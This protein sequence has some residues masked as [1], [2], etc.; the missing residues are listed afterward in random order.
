MAAS[1]GPRSVERALDLLDAVAEG[2]GPVSAKAL[3]RRVGC[4]LS[5]VYHLLGTLTERGHVVRTAR[6]YALGHRVPHLHRAYGRQVRT[7]AAMREVLP[8]VRRATGAEAYFT[9][10]R[11]G[12]ISVVDSTAPP[13]DGADPFVVAC[14]RRAH[15]TA[16][17]KA[18]LA[19]VP[20]AARTRYLDRHGLPRLTAHTIT[21]REEFEAELARVRRTGLAVSVG[22]ADDALSCLA[23]SLAVPL[24]GAEGAGAEAQALSVSLPTREYRDRHPRVAEVLQRAAEHFAD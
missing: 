15:A 2:D 4:S 18:L 9:V 22:E 7:A 19:A 23:V 16:H 21:A 14:E 12:E 8:A 1:D 10:F 13:G 17:G 11:G 3:A 24:D 5:T 20:R 6:G